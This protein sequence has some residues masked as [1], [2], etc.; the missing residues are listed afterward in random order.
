M[1]LSGFLNRPVHFFLEKEPFNKWIVRKSIIDDKETTS[2]H[3]IFEKNSIELYCNRAEIIESIFLDS[4]EYFRN[5]DEISEVNFSWTRET[6]LQK[7]GLPEKSGP[8]VSFSADENYGGW[9]RFKYPLYMIHFQ[10]DY[11]SAKLCK[12]IFMSNEICI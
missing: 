8:S 2:I 11:F 7:F 5:Y 6:V 1:K 10:Y 4:D 3:Y 12:L 9:D